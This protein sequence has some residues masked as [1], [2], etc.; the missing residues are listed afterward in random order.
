MSDIFCDSLV[1]DILFFLKFY[2]FDFHRIHLKSLLQF[3]SDSFEMSCRY[4]LGQSSH[5]V[6]FLN[7]QIFYFFL[8]ECS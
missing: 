8:K 3:S 2:Y 4:S 5:L 7:F 6:L 1:C